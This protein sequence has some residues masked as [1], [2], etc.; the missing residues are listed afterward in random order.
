MYNPTTLFCVLPPVLWESGPNHGGPEGVIQQLLQDLRA[1]ERRL[2]KGLNLETEAT[3]YAECD[4]QLQSAVRAAA[5][6]HSDP[7]L[8]KFASSLQKSHLPAVCLESDYFDLLV[9]VDTAG[10]ESRFD[11]H[12]RFGASYYSPEQVASHIPLF[13]K[14]ATEFGYR[15]RAGV[16]A[17]LQWLR[18]FVL[19]GRHGV[20]ELLELSLGTGTAKPMDESKRSK[21]VR[22][23][24]KFT[25]SDSG[26]QLKATSGEE[27][28]KQR[29][30]AWI[31]DALESDSTV[32]A[33]N[34]SHVITTEVLA[35]YVMANQARHD[36]KQ[37]IRIVYGDGSEARPFP[38]RCLSNKC[39]AAANEDAVLSIGLISIRHLEMDHAIDFAWF[40]N[41]E[42]SRGGSS[43]ETDEY[44]YQKSLEQLF[45]LQQSYSGKHL[46]LRMYHTGLEPAVVGFYRAVVTSLRDAEPNQHWLRVIPSYFLGENRYQSGMHW[47]AL[48]ENR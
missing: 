2:R 27:A 43:A 30:G 20:V 36:Q 41:Q 45:D 38:L 26:Q 25:Q 12:L 34:Q 19:P 33:S 10:P 31:E 37:K 7:T 16:R 48:P 28:M 8:Q 5:D 42:T 46:T 9:R 23:I 3:R 32:N 11:P 22:P 1:T 18:D 29:L 21:P 15:E 17:R 40:R 14:L 44:C 6:V 13:E 39:L 4:E 47:P 35:K 24:S